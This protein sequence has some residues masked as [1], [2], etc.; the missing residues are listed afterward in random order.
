MKKCPYCGDE[1]EDE[2]VFCRF[3]GQIIPES[4]NAALP[5]L[6]ARKIRSVWATGAL[7]AAVITGLAAVGTVIGYF[8][9][10][11]AVVGIVAIGTIP[12]FI[13]LWLTCTLITWRWRKAGKRRLLE[14][15]T[16]IT[17]ILI[18]VTLSLVAENL[19]S[20]AKP[21]NLAPLV[22]PTGTATIRPTPVK[23]GDCYPWDYISPSQVGLNLCIY[24]KVH[25]FGGTLI[26][27]SRDSTQVRIIYRP[28]GIYLRLQQGD[29]VMAT[30]PVTSENGILMLTT[31]EIGYCPTGFVP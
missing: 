28:V 29:C 8:K 6:P 21:L 25:E 12:S 14:I 31:S 20:P 11:R 26:L 9:T 16:I 19:L 24:G 18:W 27:F 30:G 15:F 2:A 7:W 4:V 3:C 10:P 1:N 23:L 5:A 17:F 13:F 22:V